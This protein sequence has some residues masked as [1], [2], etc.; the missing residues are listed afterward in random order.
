MASADFLV[1]TKWHDSAAL[2]GYDVWQV[3]PVH[4]CW[5][6]RFCQVP[7]HPEEACPSYYTFP[8]YLWLQLLWNSQR[9]NGYGSAGIATAIGLEP[10]IAFLPKVG[11]MIASRSWYM[12]FQEGLHGRPCSHNILQYRN[13][14]NFVHLRFPHPVVFAFSIAFSIAKWLISW[15]IPLCPSIT[16]EIGV[17]KQLPVSPGDE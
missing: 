8:V 1:S 5:H 16:A 10:S 4:Y 17:S 14:W 12:P 9:K 11:T 7:S 2:L 13:D 15:P 3:H 6:D